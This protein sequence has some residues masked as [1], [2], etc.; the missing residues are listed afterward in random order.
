MLVEAQRED[1][2][3]QT[4]KP[5]QRSLIQHTSAIYRSRIKDANVHVTIQYHICTAV[6][7]MLSIL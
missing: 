6:T 3:K 7:V 2:I 1:T 5:S 4:L